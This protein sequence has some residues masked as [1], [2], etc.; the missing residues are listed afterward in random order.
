MGDKALVVFGYCRSVHCGRQR[1]QC[2]PNLEA[3]RR[4]CRS[5]GILQAAALAVLGRKRKFGPKKLHCFSLIL[6]MW[7]LE[8][9]TL[10]VC[11]RQSMRK[12]FPLDYPVTESP[13]TSAFCCT[14]RPPATSLLPCS[15]CIRDIRLFPTCMHFSQVHHFVCQA[16]S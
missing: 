1:R 13:L 8:I 7:F 11:V 12:G 16:N 3:R 9:E 4:W 2:S 10:E 5:T 14:P 6:N 15:S